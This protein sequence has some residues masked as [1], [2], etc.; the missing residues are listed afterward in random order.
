MGTGSLAAASLPHWGLP[1]GQ[2]TKE[3]NC[4]A[5]R[6]KRCRCRMCCLPA[7]EI[8]FLPVK[9]KDLFQQRFIADGDTL[10][11]TGL[12]DAPARAPTAQAAR[13]AQAGFVVQ[14]PNMRSLPAEGHEKQSLMAMSKRLAALQGYA[15]AP[16]V[17]PAIQSGRPV[18]YVPDDTL[19]WEQAREMDIR[20]EKDLFGAVVPHAYMASKPITH[21]LVGERAIA[22]TGWVH[23]VGPRVARLV[24]PGFSAFSLEDARIGIERMLEQ[25]PARVKLGGGIGGSGQYVVRTPRDCEETLRGMDAAILARDGMV[26][27]QHLEDIVT[28]SVG[29]TVVGPWRIAYAGTQQLTHDHSGQLVYGGSSLLIVRG[30]FGVLL[31][32]MLA[33]E[34][35]AA[36]ALARRFDTAIAEEI[37]AFMGSRRNYDVIR[38]RNP[39]GKWTS[40]VLE[41]SWRIG[42][43][44][45]AE[46]AA[47]EA[48][49]ADRSLRVVRARC[50]EDYSSDPDIPAHANVH[51][52]GNDRKA[53]RLTKYSYVERNTNPT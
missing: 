24:L 34:M 28:Y 26:I 25:G 39:Q 27:E 42:G 35:R 45:P 52:S 20:S 43:A 9:V 13:G 1:L 37:P 3:K 50:V 4:N 16:G 19:T 49:S 30:G 48:F 31:R 32:Q 51:F 12:I 40:G 38:G 8:P 10:N 11:S 36:V 22:P 6:T 5:S 44:S 2:A 33:P 46:I 15:W 7:A 14:H 21:A 29:T 18:Y 47:L 23:S 41:Q 53:G 17:D